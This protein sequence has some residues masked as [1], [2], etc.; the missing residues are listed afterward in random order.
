MNKD[1]ERKLDELLG[2]MPK[3]DY[4]LDA[5]LDEDETEEFNRIVSQQPRTNT[6]GIRPRTNTDLQEGKRMVWQ[7]VA[8]AACLLMIIGIGVTMKL[9]EE[10]NTLSQL[11]LTQPLPAP[12]G[13]G[14]GVGSVSSKTLALEEERKPL[15]AK[16][17]PVVADLKSATQETGDFKSPSTQA[18]V[19]TTRHLSLTSHHSSLHEDT[20]GSAIWQREENVALALQMLSDCEQTI[21][22]EE[23]E[24]RNNII[25]AT[26]NAT[27][28]PAKAQLLLN[29]N[30]DYMVVED[31]GPFIIEL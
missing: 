26:F 6:E 4:D 27:P 22:R 5:W 17:S 23:Q 2:K 20:L 8:A 16:V 28:Q 9:T 25:R 10:D 3:R 11:S 13:E 1:T 30:G 29:D 19:L 12:Q 31:N 24:L 21:Q 14:L 18:P 7:W 15:V